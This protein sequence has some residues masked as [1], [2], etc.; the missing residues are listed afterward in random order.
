VSDLRENLDQMLRTVDP[1]PAP[2]QAVVRRGKRIR[3][4]RRLAAAASVVAVVAFAVAGYPALTHNQAAP[5]PTPV[6]HRPSVTDVPP[7]PGAPKNLVAS[8]LINGTP[9]K[10]VAQPPATQ[11]CF[12]AYD[13]GWRGTDAAGDCERGTPSA[14]SPVAFQGFGV[15]GRNAVTIGQVRADVQYVVVTLADGTQLKLIPV[16]VHGARYVAFPSPGTVPVMSATVYLADGGQGGT[17]IPFNA[18]DGVPMFAAWLQP[19]QHPQSQLRQVVASDSSPGQPWSLTAYAGPWGICLVESGATGTI[20][21]TAT[22]CMVAAPRNVTEI[23]GS[24]GGGLPQ[25]FYGSA[26]A[27]VSM[28]QITLNDGS[29]IAV[30]PVQV[31]QGKLFAFACGGMTVTKIKALMTPRRLSS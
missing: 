7:G 16:T 11:Q 3:T 19:G 12:V 14:A 26:P 1:G 30:V 24:F 31:G 13:P 23:L 4:R 9:W 29:V 27:A 5:T 2:V 10:V 18:P 22:A 21:A 6:T 8:G 28:L 15:D 20:T 25:V 17:A